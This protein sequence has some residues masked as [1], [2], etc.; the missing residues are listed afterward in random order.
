MSKSKLI[1]AIIPTYGRKNPLLETIK[2]V[3]DA[4]EYAKV[5]YQIIIVD[6]NI[7]KSF[8]NFAQKVAYDF[9]CEYLFSNIN[10]PCQARN[11]AFHNYSS[12]EFYSFLDDDIYLFS[13]YYS[14]ALSLINKNNNIDIIVGR[15]MNSSSSLTSYILGPFMDP[16]NSKKNK[17]NIWHVSGGNFFS[18]SCVLNKILFDENYCGYSYAEDLDFGFRAKKSGFNITY[19]PAI[20][21]LH[22]SS[23]F[24][25]NLD[26]EVLEKIIGFS[27]F[28]KKNFKNK[29]VFFY[30]L[31]ILSF[32][33]S[34]STFK[35]LSV[36]LSIV[37]TTLKNKTTPESLFRFKNHSR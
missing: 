21:M 13:D 15:T 7:E 18:K 9:N 25:R 11:L 26:N 34:L 2:S 17:N 16:R 32:L 20:K 33:L 10:G 3:I 28:W 24:G 6:N 30:L 27:Y 22:F 31:R 1:T 4:F 37:N 8:S 29:Y 12:S 23:N 36:F 5:D 14:N 35:K 19:S